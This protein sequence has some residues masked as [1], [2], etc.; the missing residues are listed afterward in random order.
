MKRASSP[1]LKSLLLARLHFSCFLWGGINLGGKR[2]KVSEVGGIFAV[3]TQPKGGPFFVLGR[4]V[5]ERTNLPLEGHQRPGEK[6][7][8]SLHQG[9]GD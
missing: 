7:C 1:G 3:A 9:E 4:E 8:G 2:G 5:Q 6:K